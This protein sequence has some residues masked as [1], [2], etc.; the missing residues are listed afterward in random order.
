MAHTPCLISKTRK[1]N[2]RKT[3]CDERAHHIKVCVKNNES[4]CKNHNWS[5]KSYFYCIFLIIWNVGIEHSII[6]VK[7]YEKIYFMVEKIPFEKTNFS[8][9]TFWN[10]FIPA[11]RADQCMVQKWIL[12]INSIENKCGFFSILPSPHQS[13]LGRHV[14]L[15]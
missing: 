14:M 8:L 15:F 6:N 13:G 1:K 2:W 5:M 4:D 10:F 12:S 3:L 11:D 7:I 9:N